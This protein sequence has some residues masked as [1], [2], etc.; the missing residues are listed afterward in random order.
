MFLGHRYGQRDVIW[1]LG[2]DRNPHPDEPQYEATWPEMAVGLRAGDGGK[3]LITFHPT[4]VYSSSQWFHDAPWLDFNMW[5]TS[6]RI[7][8]DYCATLLQDYTRRPVK[9]FLD[10]ETR[11]EHSHCRF[12]GKD[13]CGV[14]MT[15]QRVRQAAY[16]AIL[17]GALGHTYGCRDVWSF[18]IP[19]DRP[20]GRD[21]DTHWKEAIQFPAARQLRHWRALFTGYPWYKLVPDLSSS[22]VTHGNC[23]GS[24]HIQ[25][26][27]SQEGEF[28]LVYV[29]D[30]MPVWVDLGRLAGQAVDAQ[31]FDPVTGG[32]RFIRRYHDKAMTRFEWL[33]NPG[34]Q[35]HVL[36]LSAIG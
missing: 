33:E 23:E 14:R 19:S 13:A 28:A 8:V 15:P 18:H 21:V 24:P 29:P 32:Y 17:C 22:L 27:V 16:Y 30:D 10:G 7:Q 35:D 31:W 26:A 3:N 6:T 25:G 9:P 2:G 5:Q 4:A 11:Y 34:E 1:V 12:W 36:V 20:A